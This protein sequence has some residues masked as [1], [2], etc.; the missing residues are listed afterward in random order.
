MFWNHTAL[1]DVTTITL[2]RSGRKIISFVFL[3]EAESNAKRIEEYYQK[4][5][6]GSKNVN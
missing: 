3:F 6:N 4:Q 5:G 1:K 2:N